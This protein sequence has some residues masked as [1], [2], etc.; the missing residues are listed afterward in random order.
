VY[1]V[2]SSSIGNIL[3]WVFEMYCT[4]QS[5]PGRKVSIVGG[6][7][8]CHS[9]QKVYIYI[10]ICM[11]PIPNGFGD[12]AISLYSSLDLAPNIVLPSR[13]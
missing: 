10:Y 2:Y 1:H 11:C 6:L 4:I 5:V 9:K 13:M 3:M 8:I 7:S 12:R